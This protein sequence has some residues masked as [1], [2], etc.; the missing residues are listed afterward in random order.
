MTPLLSAHR[1][2]KSFIKPDG[3]KLAVLDGIGLDLFAG[4]IVCLLGASG[5]GKT[6]LLRIL[7]GLDTPDAGSIDS[8]IARPGPQI[9][10]FSQND[11]LLPWRTTAANVALGMEL[12]GHGTKQARQAAMD[13]LQQVGL[14]GFE[15]H[16]PAQLSGGMQQRVLLARIM[17]LRPKLLFLDEPMSNLD[18]LARRDLATLVKNYV[19]EEEAAAL[20]VTHSVEEACFLADRI[21]FVTRP[22]ARLSGE[23]RLAD[24]KA[25]GILARGEAMDAVMRELWR[26]LGAAA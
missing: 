9:G 6:T 11:L 24:D 25:D 16:Y 3:G 21:L 12:T 2:E 4:E 18:V 23:I 26:T 7:S 19:R 17:A 14:G 5:C 15:T 8:A 20:V 10:A 22:P 1:I 13:A